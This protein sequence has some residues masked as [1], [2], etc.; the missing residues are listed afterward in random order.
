[1][2]IRVRPECL[3]RV[4]KKQKA[5][6]NNQEYLVD[7][8]GV[9]KDTVNK[10]L[11]GKEISREN[12]DKIC[13]ALEYS[14]EEITELIE[15]V[16]NFQP[17]QP[18]HQSDTN[19]QD[20]CST[21]HDPNFVGRENA[22]TDRHFIAYDDTW[23]GRHQTI[24]TIKQKITGSSRIVILN[25]ITG[26]GKT[27]LAEKLYTEL[28]NEKKWNQLLRV[29]FDHQD[30]SDFGS[31]IT[32]VDRWLQECG[33][34][35]TPE[36]RQ[37]ILRLQKRL[38]EYIAD[39]YCLIIIDSLEWIL[40]GNQEHGWG[41]F[42]DREWL[43]FFRLFLSQLQCYSRII[44]TTQ[45]LPEDFSAGY[46]NFCFSQLITGLEHLEQLELFKQIGIET[47]SQT[48]V[49]YLQRIGKVYEGHS[50]TLKVIAGT[51][52][53]VYQGNILAYWQEEG[54]EEIEKV[55]KDLESTQEN[56]T[57]AWKLHN[58]N[59]ALYFKVFYRFNKAFE[60]LKQ[61][62]YYS[63]LLLCITS[64][65]LSPHT[66][67]DLLEHLADEGCSEKEQRTALQTLRDEQLIEIII[68]DNTILFRLH[69]LIRS[70]AYE[71]FLKLED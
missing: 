9:G 28:T 57:D 13:D 2:G 62:D 35:V 42:K 46:D 30:Q 70:V 31:F 56:M 21:E 24:V 51:I 33:I 6:Y 25:G 65:Y 59:R 60:R 11:T 15:V 52:K 61:Y 48:E 66:K 38:I 32:V 58:A 50:L 10:F 49:N 34:L 27:A 37:D 12:F 39:N 16:D 63:Y 71:H 41:E 68:Q 19:K 8:A 20:A 54:K 55:E 22:I 64:T 26:I 44:I 29:N 53:T 18:K 3:D 40:K 1:M 17:S 67:E 36:D 7:E 5:L 45:H 4:R 23:V 47:K 43:N 69:N 14:I